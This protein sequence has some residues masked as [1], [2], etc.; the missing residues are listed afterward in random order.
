[1]VETRIFSRSDIEALIAAGDLI[2]IANQD[3]LR[4]NAWQHRH[5][6]GKLVIHH[7]VGRD[8][9]TE[10]SVFH[11]VEVLNTMRRYR[12]GKI[13]GPWTNLTPPIQDDMFAKTEYKQQQTVETIKLV[14]SAEQAEKALELGGECNTTSC[15]KSEKSCPLSKAGR[16]DAE[17]KGSESTLNS[18]KTTSTNAYT[19][20]AIKDE[21][22]ASIAKYP[23]LDDK[24]QRE[25]GL[26]FQE[27]HQRVRDEGFYT[28]HATEYAKELARYS[29]LF[30]V[31]I[32]CL[33]SGW[34]TV[35][36]CAL[37]LFWHQI[38]FTAHDAGHLGITHNFV[39]DT[40]I[41]I[42][43][44]NFC[45]GLSIGW[46]KSSHN[47]HHLVTNDPVHDPDIQ[48][49]PLFAT[50]PVFFTS[51]RSTYY[52]GFC[53]VWDK[54][55]DIA[56]KYQKLTY[57]P[58]MAVARFN[59]YFLSWAHLC[60]TR[61]ASFGNATWTRPTEIVAIVSYIYLYFY[62][63]LYRNIPTWQARAVFLLVSH[64]ITMPLHVQITLSH[65]G[66]STDDLG[67]SESFAQRQLRTTMDVACPAWLDWVHGGLQFQ[68]IHHLFPR[69][70]RHNLR[71][72]QSLVKDFCAETGIEYLS[73]GFVDANK[74]VLSRLQQVADQAKLMAACQAHMAATGESGLH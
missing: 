41:G 1:M 58:V 15:E 20:K 49:V 74:G 16:S 17:K 61:S 59:L 4:L 14:K 45:C 71:R 57:Y 40:L 2:I 11:T 13:E 18:T 72:L 46:W 5:P 21:L 34:Y 51:I 66:T 3:V 69:V 38:M 7:M 50:S 12:I 31:F 24:T 55:A 27:L 54:A 62:V 6:G 63:L 47:V 43:I 60:S 48:N 65:W 36:A 67:A 22:D 32:F 28:C 25:I 23:S 26:R 35:S 10:L 73:L 42:F 44:G 53:F 56:V 30:G 39:I 19:T 9:T 52:D 29:L 37:G 8:A 64:L 70:P 68:A 33:R